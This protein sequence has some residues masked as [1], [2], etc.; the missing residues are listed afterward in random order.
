MNGTPVKRRGLWRRAI[1]ILASTIIFVLAAVIL[2]LVTAPG[3]RMIALLANRLASGPE[4]SIEIDS[5]SGLLTGN[6]RIGRVLVSDAEGQ[7]FLLIKDITASFSPTALLSAG[8]NV[9]QLTIGRIELA[10]LPESTAAPEDAG[11]PF[12]LPLELDIRSIN[13]PEIVLGPDVAGQ[14]AALSATGSVIA[15]D[16]L[17]R[18]ETTLNLRR[19]DGN[20]GA[21]DLAFRFDRPGDSLALKASLDEPDG[22][23]FSGLAGLPQGDAFTVTANASGT[24]DNWSVDA[25]AR[26]AGR[27]VA[28]ITGKARPLDGGFAAVLSG[29]GRLGLFMPKVARPLFA[30]DST[31][32]ADFAVPGNGG[33]RL[34]TFTLENNA[35]TASAE[36]VLEADGG[37]FATARVTPAQNAPS[38][39]LD[40]VRLALPALGVEVSGTRQAADIRVNAETTR[41]EADA[42]VAENLNAL[43]TLSAFD[44]DAVSGEG[45][46]II[47]AGSVGTADAILS[48]ALAGGLTLSGPFSVSDGTK[49]ETERFTLG[50]G[51]ANVNL[52]GSATLAGALDIAFQGLA[53]TAIA[54]DGMPALLG[55]K[56]QFGA[57]VNR[58]LQGALTISGLTFTTEKLDGGGDLTLV[59]GTLKASAGLT[60]GDLSAF[61][62]Q[63]SGTLRADVTL[64]GDVAAPDFSLTL[65]PGDLVL[66]GR[67]A[68]GLKLIAKGKV[69]PANPE[70]D[71]ALSGSFDGQPVS[72]TI[73]LG[74]RDGVVRI[75]PVALDFAGNTA[76]GSLVLDDTFRPDGTINLSLGD[77]APLAALAGQKIAGT[78]TAKLVF[79]PTGTD[80]FSLALTADMPQVT[81]DGFS[82]SGAVADMSVA[83]LPSAPA[84]TGKAT[85]KAIAASGETVGNL[86]LGFTQRDDGRTAFDAGASVRGSP[87]RLKGSL[88]L[89]DGIADIELTEGS[90]RTAGLPLSIAGPSRIRAGNGKAEI[91]PLLL[92]PGGGTV[93]ISGEAGQALDLDIAINGVSLARAAPGAGVSGTVSGTVKV[94]GAAANP[95]A[96]YD[97]AV[98]GFQAAAAG[99][100]APPLAIR[101]SGLFRDGQV[102]FDGRGDG[103]GLAFTANGATRITGN[104]TIDARI[105]GSLPFAL[106]SRQLSAQ[107]LAL[108][109]AARA[110]LAV[111]GPVGGPVINGTITT[112]GA[113]LVDARSGIAINDL[114]ATIGLEGKRAVIR[115]L[116]GN[117]SGG[118]TVSGEGSVS[119]ESTAGFPAA[120]RLAVNR[121]R[122]ADGKLVATRLDADLALEGALVRAPLL[123]GT[124]RLDRTTLTVPDTLPEAVSK[125]GITHKNASGSVERQ[126]ERLTPDTGNG[127]SGG[128][129]INL[130]VTVTAPSQIFVRGRGIDAEFGGSVRLTGAS[131]APVATGGFDLVRGRLSVLGKR[132]DFTR[133]RIGFAGSL[134]PDL[135]FAASTTA[136]S[137]TA[138]VT[139]TGPADRPEFG[140]SS[141]PSLPDDEVLALILFG[142]SLS[143]LSPLQIA[144]LAQAAAEL[145]GVTGPGGGLVNRLRAATGLDDLDVR[146]DAT[147]GETTVGAG[148]YLNDRTYL[149]LERGAGAGTGKAT[150]DLSIGKGVRLRGEASESGATK[151]GIFFEREY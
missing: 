119:L 35:L 148:T 63:V 26:V 121:A 88:G 111:S 56:L 117:L 48:R 92:S 15:T 62:D 147:T 10:R 42:I 59:D 16:G 52:S 137:S 57:S 64:E 116:S 37:I 9:E 78:G 44:L 124:I 136:G 1:L 41:I 24:L 139:V 81:G 79:D 74:R 86:A 28:A 46:V 94:S 65:T 66:S 40:A 29:A 123:S 126:A 120:L 43:L 14:A 71:L 146:T 101:A 68:A 27:Q 115:Q 53:N 135:G 17:D 49:L 129:G 97:L 11:G 127:G 58:D 7:G 99:G 19:A 75:D 45:Q 51:T 108:S 2:V 107:G 143:N 131:A 87:L 50:T 61:S 103:G 90:Y 47:N 98:S 70:A 5:V 18:I 113:R 132:L 130:D 150:I 82:V 69:D 110:D 67:D 141:S 109:G 133:G 55:P 36:G 122:Y 142:R 140:F 118:G 33:A 80:A 13:L 84:L 102:T 72:G 25:G 32:T 83:N 128:S 12:V 114:A 76:S 151:G 100:A 125:L 60:A 23:L 134:T 20:T 112:S 3:A 21:L 96:R 73:T 93:R 8:L 22:G 6:L 30:G 85:V 34:N 89:A 106:L 38:L 77:L 145:T 105:T 4:R 31:L 95:Q 39:D 149:G 144:Q 54:G 138:T 91:A 104:P